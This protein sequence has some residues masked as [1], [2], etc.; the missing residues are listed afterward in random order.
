MAM[1]ADYFAKTSDAKEKRT[2]Q[3]LAKASKNKTFPELTEEDKTTYAITDEEISKRFKNMPDKA[4][5]RNDTKEKDKNV[6]VPSGNVSPGA[7]GGAGAGSGAGAGEG[8]VA[9]GIRL[10]EPIKK[11]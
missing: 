7:G 9:E 11:E 4:V 3:I 1:V 2:K 5:T 6:T 10:F 8:R